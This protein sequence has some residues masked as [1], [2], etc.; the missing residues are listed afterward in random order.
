MERRTQNSVVTWSL[1][2]FRNVA[3][4]PDELMNKAAGQ[5]LTSSDGSNSSASNSHLV[6][7]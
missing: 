1:D 6:T 4:I 7:F 3:Q 5:S 2:Y